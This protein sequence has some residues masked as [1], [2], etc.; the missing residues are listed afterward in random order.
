MRRKIFLTG[1]SGLL[2]A[3]CAVAVSQAAPAF[4][5]KKELKAEQKKELKAIGVEAAKVVPLISKKKFGEATK[6]I[7]IL[8]ERFSK[9]AGELGLKESDPSLKSVR[10][11][12]NKVRTQ[13]TK[14]MEKGGSTFEKS[15]ATV[16]AARCI[17]CHGEESNSGLRLDTFEGLE[18]GGR[19]GQL[20]VPGDSE[21]SLLILRLT[22]P[23]EQHR[24]PLGKESLSEKE[25]LGIANWISEGAN[26]DG[27]KTAKMVTLAKSA[28][29]AKPV[30]VAN[31]AT[32]SNFAKETGSETVH[33]L[34]DLMPEMVDTCGRCHNDTDK[35]S[36][37]SVMS[38]EKIMK[39]GDSGPVV[40]PGKLDESRI[41][42]LVNG[43]DTPVMPMGN[44][45]GIT[46]KWYDSLK[47]WIEEGAKFDG[48]DPKQN[49]PSL[50]ERE[51][52]ARLKFTPEQWLERRQKSAEEAWKKTFPNASPNRRESKQFLIFGDVPDDRLEKIEKW[53]D[54]QVESLRQTFKEKDE[55]VWRGKLAVFVFKER[56]GYEEFNNSIHKRETPREIVGHSNVSSTMEEV[57]I[58]L[59][60][61]GDSASES[62]PGMRVNVIE[63]ITSA[64]LKRNGQLPEWLTR[65]T[66][67][68]MAHQAD[69][70]NP[71]LASMPRL[72]S[73]I[74]Q[75]SFTSGPET[76]F[77]EGTFSA[78]EVGPVG[79]TLVEFLLK[80]EKQNQFGQFVQKLQSGA[81]VDA[82]I[83]AVYRMDSKSLALAFA[84]SLPSSAKKGKK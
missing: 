29:V 68:A 81:T 3:M 33:F 71:Y 63:Q 28:A 49:F 47:T 30:A 15:V 72:A 7:D 67:L 78:A 55:L 45:T 19:T 5:Q 79:C 56:F 8:E 6:A 32:K 1:L 26:F 57:Y 48:T 83:K 77:V 66:G 40:V 34:K 27:D 69:S 80:R 70:S 31:R 65:G 36:G 44:Q 22:T 58:A 17:E 9:L 50:Q 13:L 25:I 38:F 23:D 59:Q 35:R 12:L 54:A 21:S 42:R 74:L 73:K 46:R 24:M 76:M 4:E 39:G 84:S 16:L 14:A 41:W 20:I 18:K 53:A 61:V 75:D 51:A 43:D 62:S 64:Y 2:V 60:D 10:G 11:Q 52:E 37:F 82:A